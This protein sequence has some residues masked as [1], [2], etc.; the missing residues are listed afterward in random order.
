MLRYHKDRICRQTRE[1]LEK[2]YRIVLEANRRGLEAV[3]NGILA[4]E[5]DSAAREFIKEAGYG[6]NFGHGLAMVSAEIHED[7]TLSF[8]AI[9]S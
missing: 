9:S 8:G 3:R 1:E 4:K 6:D 2:I 5:A 7:P